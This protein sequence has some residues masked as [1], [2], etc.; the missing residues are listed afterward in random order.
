[1]KG[2]MIKDFLVLK[3]YARTL[4]MILALYVAIAYLSKSAETMSGILAVVCALM[5][6][7]TF[8]YDDA[9]K[10]NHYA[11]TLPV[12]RRQMVRARYLVAI[13]MCLVGVLV[14]TLVTLAASL[15]QGAAPGLDFLGFMG[16]MALGGLLCSS[17]TMPLLYKFG[18]EK[19]RVIILLVGMVPAMAIT[20]LGTT[21][22]EA[23]APLGGLLRALMGLAPLL[24]LALLGLSYLISVRIFSV[25]EV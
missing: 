17:L 19:A 20:A 13:V 18:M 24:G 21:L 11:F 25:K 3:S 12:S 1:M 9:A 23:G 10:W 16:S 2:L 5:V 8:A 7:S 6:N 15:A 4:V 14:G 22:T